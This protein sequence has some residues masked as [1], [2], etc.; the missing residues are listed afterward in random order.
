MSAA[1]EMKYE[2]SIRLVDLLDQHKVPYIGFTS[3]FKK[4]GSK[5]SAAIG[6]QFKAGWMDWTFEKCKQYNESI[7]SH[8][9]DSI[10]V[11]IK[12]SPFVVLDNDE[13][14]NDVD[15]K[16]E[17]GNVWQ[18]T[19][20]SK[21]LCHA[22]FKKMD[23]D[24]SKD[25][26]DAYGKDAGHLSKCDI[27]YTNVF[28]LV[29]AEL[30][31][32]NE[33]T[34]F[35]F[36]KNHP[37]PIDKNVSE[38]VIKQKKDTEPKI[39]PD[40]KTIPILEKKSKTKN[41]IEIELM[42]DLG[43]LTEKTEKYQDWFDCACAMKRCEVP[44]ELF[45]EFSRLNKSKYDE[46]KN[47]KIWDGIDIEK[48]GYNI[49]S[50]RNWCRLADTKLYE[51]YFNYF[52]PLNILSAGAFKIEQHVREKFRNLVYVED[53][54][55]W[56]QYN[57]LD[58]IWERK[59]DPT[60]YV[61]DVL[62]KHID[63]SIAFVTDLITN[64]DDEEKK[65]DL[66][67]NVKDYMKSEKLFN[68][69]SFTNQF[70]R[71]LKTDL[72]DNHFVKKLDANPNC[73]AFKNGMLDV[74]TKCFRN[75]LKYDDYLTGFIKLDYSKSTAE[76]MKW[77][78]EE[79]IFKICN[80]NKEQAD[81][82]KSMLGFSLLG[83]PYKEKTVIGLVGEKANNGK[84]TPLA[85][86]A[87][88]APYYV[89]LM[90]NEALLKGSTKAHKHLVAFEN[91]RIVYVEEVPERKINTDTLK[92]LGDGKEIKNE[93]MFGTN[94]TITLRAKLFMI[95]QKPMD[96][97]TDEGIR[98]RY[99][100]MQFNNRF[101]K[102]DQE[103]YNLVNDKTIFKADKDMCSKLEG[104]Y[105]MAFLNLLID[106]GHMYLNE[107]QLKKIPDFFAKMTRETLLNND[108]KNTWWDENIEVGK[109]FKCQKEEVDS[110]KEGISMKDL[111]SFIKNK[112]FAYNK[113]MKKTGFKVGGWLGF[114]IKQNSVEEEEDGGQ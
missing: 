64:T 82:Y 4:D 30:F 101:L 79:V 57:E 76:E 25:L 33:M 80:C 13:P 70:M 2:R 103:D 104:Q 41:V 31:Y 43:L 5:D 75:R 68:C 44:Y 90:N 77:V 29:D 89:K 21:G 55:I 15:F 96:F 71:L 56:F 54:N 39:E 3:C 52:I 34:T 63:C 12:K 78:D 91:A 49:G 38:P 16:N 107:G 62:I 27:R 53:E 87:K 112:G 24:G 97:A 113:Q 18:S 46:P 11:N 109:E 110:I 86:L 1:I 7:K 69:G 8:N 114:R 67:D 45:D 81:Y 58:C 92:E 88:I 9:Y 99:K 102:D 10:N 106:Y 73:I 14:K 66:K 48:N 50:L 51:K 35:D 85:S 74:A 72:N 20:V 59:K 95:S 111:L 28:E 47:R 22:W 100:Q 98:T 36:K 105:A 42:I 94:K 17:F 108:V 84:T 93:V 23:N 65:K 6:R 61:V 83:T 19:S 32:N 40:P 26:T 37:K 60:Y